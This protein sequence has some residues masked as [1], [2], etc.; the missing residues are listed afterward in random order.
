MAEIRVMSRAAPM[1]FGIHVD[2]DMLYCG[3]IPTIGRE[4]HEKPGP[5]IPAR[6]SDFTRGNSALFPLLPQVGAYSR[7]IAGSNGYP[8]AE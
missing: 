2:Q 8:S 1:R 3:T 4:Q 5:P 6:T 7:F